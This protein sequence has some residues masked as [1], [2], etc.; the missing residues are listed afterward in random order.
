MTNLAPIEEPTLH[1]RV[2]RQLIERFTPYCDDCKRV[3]WQFYL[4]TEDEARRMLD[5][6]YILNH[7][8]KEPATSK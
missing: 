3:V 1:G 2:Q 4:D 5:A 7:T 8:T 6:H